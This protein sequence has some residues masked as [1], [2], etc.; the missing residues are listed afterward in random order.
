MKRFEAGSA[1]KVNGGGTITVTRRTD[2]FITFEG[3][4]AGKRRI[5]KDD[6]FGLG[7]NILIPTPHTGFKLFC[8][9]EFKEG[10]K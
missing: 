6:L 10:E 4:F 8:F 3:D 5:I 7:E 9:A 2:H 1:Y